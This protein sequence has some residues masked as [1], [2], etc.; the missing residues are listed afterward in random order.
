MTKDCDTHHM[1]WPKVKS[2][3]ILTNSR[4]TGWMICMLQVQFCYDKTL[5]LVVCGKLNE[6]GAARL[7]GTE[8]EKGTY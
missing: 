1:E 7:E 6:A 3:N 8:K 2:D 4:F 5:Q